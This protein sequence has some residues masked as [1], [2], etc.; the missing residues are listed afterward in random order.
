MRMTIQERLAR[1]K[2]LTI[3]PDLSGMSS[4]ELLALMSAV[5]AARTMTDVF[6]DQMGPG[7]RELFE[8]LSAGGE[9]D[10]D[11]FRFMQVHGCPWDDGDND[12]P[13]IDGVG[14]RPLGAGVYPADTTKE[15][16]DAAV[17]SA[18]PEE[19]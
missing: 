16:W 6:L 3:R 17:A 4:W 7:N 1:V 15:E 18:S 10:R 14:P 19:R 8:R 9:A 13:F 12:A 5:D 2:F 11:L